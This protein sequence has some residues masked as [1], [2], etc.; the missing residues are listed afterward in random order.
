MGLPKWPSVGLIESVSDVADQEDTESVELGYKGQF[1]NNRLRVSGAVFDTDVDGQQFF[2][3]IGAISAQIP[4]NID[5]VTLKGGELDLVL[6]ATDT[7]DMSASF[8]Y[9]DSEIKAY[10]VDPTSVGNRAPYIAKTT[11]PI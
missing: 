3:F 2:S 5:K 10:A 9:T 7:L 11:V 6:K 1:L 8:G 4:T